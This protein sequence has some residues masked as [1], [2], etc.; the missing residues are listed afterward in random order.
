MALLAIFLFGCG[1]DV[2]D[3]EILSSAYRDKYDYYDANVQIMME[4]MELDAQEADDAFGVLAEAGINEE[5]SNIIQMS[6]GRG[7]TYYRIWWGADYSTSVEVYVLDGVVAKI[8][9]GED[10]L[11]DAEGD[12][13]EK[14]DDATQQVNGN[15]EASTE[16]STQPTDSTLTSDTSTE[17]GEIHVR[18]LT[19]PIKRGHTAYMEISGTPGE[20]YNI[21]VHYASSISKAADLV[22]K[23]AD[24]NGHV[25]W[26]WKVGSRTAAGTYKIIVVGGGDTLETVFIVTE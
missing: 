3:T 1:S 24:E 14:K 13:D 6:N 23:T 21:T 15:S 11:Y 8:C 19:S 22:P 5:I 17:S 16:L 12:W 20:E 4:S 25:T 10:I 9:S 2:G 26:Q 18:S 7:Q